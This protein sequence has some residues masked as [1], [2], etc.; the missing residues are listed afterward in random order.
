MK[1]TLILGW[2]LIAIVGLAGCLD[3]PSGA[4]ES[5]VI[6]DGALLTPEQ[7]AA[8]ETSPEFQAAQRQLERQ[9]ETASLDAAR[10]FQS[11]DKLGVV[12]PVNSPDGG[13]GE[14]SH[15]TFQQ[16]GDAPPVVALEPSG[17]SALLLDPKG[18]EQ[19]AD[20]FSCFGWSLWYTIS[21]YC[22]WATL[23]LF[24]DATYWLR[25]RE[26]VCCTSN[27]CFDQYEQTTVRAGCGC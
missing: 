1:K 25:Q 23:C 8:L 3:E 24:R 5:P 17:L 10:A 13:L 16:K 6:E 21:S 15:I 14:Y 22:E 7:R 11:G 2:I 4:A 20:G 12:C 27:Y 18:G 19:S 9:G 26:R